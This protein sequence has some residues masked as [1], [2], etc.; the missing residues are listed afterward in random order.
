MPQI[1]DCKTSARKG[2]QECGDPP[3]NV[4][5]S[6]QDGI[7]PTARLDMLAVA[8]TLATANKRNK[9]EARIEGVALS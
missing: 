8:E 6:G 7:E 3:A 2:A 4:F 5:S 1:K 9:T